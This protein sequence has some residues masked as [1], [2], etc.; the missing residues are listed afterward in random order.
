MFNTLKPPLGTRLIPG[1]PLTN[2]LV[3]CWLM[4]EGSGDKIYDLTGNGNDGTVSASWES[5][6]VGVGIDVQAGESIVIAASS[7]LI[8]LPETFSWT[9]IFGCVPSEATGSG[10]ERG[11]I[12]WGGY[13]D[14]VV[15]PNC[16]KSGEGGIRVFWRSQTTHIEESGPDLDGQ[17]VHY[18]LGSWANNDHRAYRNGA[19]VGESIDIPGTDGLDK[20][21]FGKYADGTQELDGLLLYVYMYDHALTPG[22]IVSI[23]ANPY[24]MF[25]PDPIWWMVQSG[26][27]GE[28]LSIPVAMHHMRQQGMS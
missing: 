11:A 25:E 3:G 26:A 18:A 5:S 13:D 27:A 23:H 1:H 28:G 17:V 10:G 24:A 22:Q 16:N 8:N 6:E 19:L 12:S 20:L 2:G 21:H 7:E 15:Y 14:I 9:C 4:N